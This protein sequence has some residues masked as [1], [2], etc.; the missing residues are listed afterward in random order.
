YTL[1]E[2]DWWTDYHLGLTRIRT[3]R[4]NHPQGALAYRLDRGGVSIVYATDHEPGAMERDQELID[5]ARDADVFISDAEFHPEEL[6]GLKRGWGHGSWKESARLARAAGVR[7]L[8]LYHHDHLRSDDELDQILAEARHEFPATLAA[9]EGMYLDL[10]RRQMRVGSRRLRISQRTPAH[11]PVEVE[12]L[13]AGR[14]VR[15]QVQLENIS[16][17]GAYFLSATEYEP[18]QHV[19]LTVRL[20]MNGNGRSG[21][22]AGNGRQGQGLAE[23]RLQ[24]FVLRTEPATLDSGWKGVA[25]HFPGR[26]AEPPVEVFP[27]P[28]VEVG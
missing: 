12:S 22:Q 7:Q 18:Q 17:H 2:F 3:C 14:A 19:S 21:R 24:G 15:E 20:P 26:S 13:Q 10:S 27:K 6:S 5:L 1:R 4:L 9:A 8:I 11:V 25:V 23:V 28:D 16:F